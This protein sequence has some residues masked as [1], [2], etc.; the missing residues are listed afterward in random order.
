MSE[1]KLELIEIDPTTRQAL[2]KFADA[3]VKSRA[4]E[5]FKGAVSPD[6]E[7]QLQRFR[8]ALALPGDRQHGAATFEKNCM[9]C[10]QMQGVGATVGPDLSGI[11]QHARE[12]LLV[13]ILDPKEGETIYTV[14]MVGLADMARNSG[15]QLYQH[16]FEI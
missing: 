9:V 5:L 13:D 15:D 8:A 10:H 4:V 2:E 6:R 14:K 16:V 3:E 7:A 1:Q 12:T 11:G